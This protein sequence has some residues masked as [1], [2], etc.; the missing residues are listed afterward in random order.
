M[1]LMKKIGSSLFIL[2]LAFSLTSCVYADDL[3]NEN[4]INDENSIVPIISLE[5]GLEDNNSDNDSEDIEAVST[6]MD[7]IKD[8]SE[9]ISST[10]TEMKDTGMTYFPLVLLILLFS[11]FGLNLKRKS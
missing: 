3:E 7:D 2:I 1:K 8:D 9:K 6:R 11:L 4:D 10:S 5:D